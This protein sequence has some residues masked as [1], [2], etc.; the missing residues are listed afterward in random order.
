[1]AE[2]ICKVCGLDEGYDR[3]RVPDGA[4]YVICS[5][6]SAESG[7]DDLD[8]AWARRYRAKWINEGAAW[9]SPKE[10]PAD[11]QLDRQMRLI[12]AVWR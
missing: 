12:L 11:W 9:F 8:L 6:C 4:Q 5:C 1:V 10:R 7:V 3:W 2:S